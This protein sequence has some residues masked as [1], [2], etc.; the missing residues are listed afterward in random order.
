MAGTDRTQELPVEPLAE[1]H[2]DPSAFDFYTALRLVERAHRDKPRIGQSRRPSDDPVRL[3][4]RP[5]LAFAPATIASFDRTN[6]PGSERME[7]LFFGLFGPNGPLPLHLTEYARD[8]ERQHSD[9]TFGRFADVFHHR[10]LSLFYRAWA[11]A[12][13]TVEFDR[14]ENDRFAAHTGS[15][16]G[17]GAPDPTG[18]AAVCDLTRLYYAGRLA[19][20]NRNAEG[21]R[22]ILAEHLGVAAAIEELVGEWLTLPEESRLRLGESAA[23]GTLGRTATIGAAIWEC[24]HRFRVVLGPLDLA[25]YRRLLPGGDLHAALAELVETWVGRELAW[26]VRLI[27]E[28]E[29]V[30]RTVLGKRRLGWTTWLGDRHSD[31]AADDLVLAPL[32]ASSGGER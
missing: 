13:P 3:A 32:T 8:R 22:A 18:S 10:L 31:A 28:A 2:R 9:P 29:E 19:S 14:P 11:S 20:P 6:G 4:Q 25:T 15:L 7:V 12:Q 21:L 30:P 5:S 27:L 24:R 26:D 23:T 17:L 16:F 1:L